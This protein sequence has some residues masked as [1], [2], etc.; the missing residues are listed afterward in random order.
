MPMISINLF[1]FAAFFLALGF[2]SHAAETGPSPL[3]AT[4]PGGAYAYV[5]TN[6]L[7]EVLQLFHESQVLR[8]VLASELFAEVQSSEGL[9]KAYA[10]KALAEHVLRMDLWEACEKLLG[11]EIGLGLYPREEA[12]QPH[13]VLLLRP[14]DQEA[15]TTQRAWIEPLLDLVAKPMESASGIRGFIAQGKEDQPVYIALHE[16]WLAVTTE[17]TLL[18]KTIALQMGSAA[19]VETLAKSAL[20]QKVAPMR[21]A[22]ESLVE[23]VIDIETISKSLGAGKRFGFSDKMS[24]PLGSLLVGGIR[25]LG[26]NSQVALLT[27]DADAD[28]FILET[29]MDG[30]PGKLEQGHQIYFCDHPKTGIMPLPKVP[31]LI[32]GFTFHREIGE[33]YRERDQ[34]LDAQVLPE[35]DKFEAGIGNILP[36]KDFGEDVMRLLGN[37]ITFV[38][39]VQNFEHLE[40]E[41]G[42]E[43]PAFAF[44]IDLAEP[45]EGEAIFQLF[46]QTL[47]SV[48]NL[49]AA[50]QQ[51][52]PWLIDT[53]IHDD[54]KITTARYL[55]KPKGKDLPIVFNFLPAAARVGDQY[56]ISSSLPLC[57]NLI[58]ALGAPEVTR[59]NENFALDLDVGPLVDILR[60]NETHLQTQR[61]V[62]GRSVNQAK[63]DIELVLAI[64]QSI[65]GLSASTSATEQG[66]TLRLSGAFNEGR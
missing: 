20:F 31:N 23:A 29:R 21:T 2:S 26:L 15:W 49:E 28:S 10:G 41:L 37:N 60:A 62:E 45:E 35:F 9:V 46:V 32:G 54:V 25:E 55:Q 13:A 1:R 18:E 4:L 50:K 11:G 59:L 36:G 64:L 5:E 48:L 52:Q 51:R 24:N 33:W 63:S 57:R 34:L 61:V 30:S 27:L 6:K 17:T 65:K 39:A 56:I 44:V 16:A 47:L 22:K 66:F 53:V 19:D 7:G 38:S 14:Q 8:H 43:L 12:K 42:I 3:S 40:G 58:N